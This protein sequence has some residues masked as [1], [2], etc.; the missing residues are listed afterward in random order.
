MTI[1]KYPHTGALYTSP[2]QLPQSPAAFEGWY[3]YKD[4]I[5][6]L[7]RLQLT[8]AQYQAEKSVLPKDEKP[9][10]RQAD[11]IALRENSDDLCATISKK[12]K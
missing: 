8:S 12:K 5:Q 6:F 9:E 7:Q 3:E 1:G 4:V 10:E 11:Q 2:S